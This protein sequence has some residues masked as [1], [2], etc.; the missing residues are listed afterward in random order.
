MWINPK[1]ADRYEQPRPPDEDGERL[2]TLGRRGGDELW[3]N[4]VTFEGLD[5]VEFRLWRRDS[6]TGEMW[7]EKGR[8]CEI[9]AYEVAELVEAL[10]KGVETPQE[11]AREADERTDGRNERRTPGAARIAP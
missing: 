1:Y 9:R 7:P 5:Y 10:H 3:L 8:G 6:G 4:R 11:P 2:L